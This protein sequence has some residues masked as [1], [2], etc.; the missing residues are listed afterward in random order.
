MAEGKF[1][2]FFTLPNVFDQKQLSLLFHWSEFAKLIF[3]EFLP[4]GDVDPTIWLDGAGPANNCIPPSILGNMCAQLCSVQTLKIHLQV[5]IAKSYEMTFYKLKKSEKDLGKP[6]FVR[7]EF[8]KCKI[9][10]FH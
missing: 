5:K 3:T 2:E 7:S 4:T 6:N 1:V 9:R 8:A 10:H